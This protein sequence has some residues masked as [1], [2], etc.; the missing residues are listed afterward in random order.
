L[1]QVPGGVLF[2]PIVLFDSSE[3]LAK[4]TVIALLEGFVELLFLA[5]LFPGGLFTVYSIAESMG[6]SL[7]GAG[8]QRP[9]RFAD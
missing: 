8:A 3:Y 2:F 5:I 4:S 6:D 7:R 9:S 1:T